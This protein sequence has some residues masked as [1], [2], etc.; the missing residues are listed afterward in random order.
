ML[1]VPAYRHILCEG[2]SLHV[3]Q[4]TLPLK[5]SSPGAFQHPPSLNP[6]S[7]QQDGRVLAAPTFY[8][9]HC[10]WPIRNQHSVLEDGKVFVLS[11]CSLS[12]LARKGEGLVAQN[13]KWFAWSACS[14]GSG[15]HAVGSGL[16]GVHAAQ[17]AVLE[18]VCV[19][20]RKRCAWSVCTS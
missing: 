1:P 8:F 18:A 13:G 5:F 16:C 7:H 19:E 9:A 20:R 6:T 17:E 2:P 12:A 4:G 14:T 15:M 11:T 10:C 3:Q